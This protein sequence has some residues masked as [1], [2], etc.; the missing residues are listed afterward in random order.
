MIWNS[1]T[2]NMR[3][4]RFCLL[5]GLMLLLPSSYAQAQDSDEEY[6]MELGVAFGGSFYMGDA[7]YTTPFKDMGF[8]AGLIGRFILNP[9][10]AVK[11]NLS[12]G[13]ISGDTQSIDNVFPEE[14]QCSFDRTIYDLGAQFEYNFWAYG[15]GMSYQGSRRFTPYILGGIGMTFA[16]KP[17]EDVVTLN[18]PIGLG[19]KYKL[20]PRWNAGCEFTMRF[21]LSDKLDV[22]NEEGLILDD[23][24]GIKGSGFKNKDSY[25]FIT[26]SIT[27]DLFPKC[28]TCNKD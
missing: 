24:Y 9:R 19:L 10:M 26:V 16:P 23:P 27:Y 8:S 18:F 4:I 6:R 28:K 25:S 2:M 7:N 5:A 11:C 20:A 15:S 1:N 22:T 12:M 17:V 21:S 13:K 14:G 3:F